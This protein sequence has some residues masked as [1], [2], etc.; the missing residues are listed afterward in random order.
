MR[1]VNTIN[2]ILKETNNGEMTIAVPSKQDV[3]S[4]RT[5]HIN[6]QLKLKIVFLK[7]K[8]GGAPTAFVQAEDIDTYLA[9]I[10]M[11]KK[12]KV[13][14]AKGHLTDPMPAAV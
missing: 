14:G 9:I 4:L 5:K 11:V 3:D 7:P 12:Y 10:K 6:D 1:T 8:K 13:L 2:D